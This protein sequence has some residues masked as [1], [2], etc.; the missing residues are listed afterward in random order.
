[1]QGGT[2]AIE[3]EGKI[4]EPDEVSKR[5]SDYIIQ[6]QAMTM[7]M[8]L[9]DKE[10]GWDG[11]KYVT[12]HVYAIDF[13]VGSQYI[14]EFTQ[15]NGQKAF[16]LMSLRLPKESEAES[17]DQTQARKILE[18]CL[19]KSFSFK[20]AHGIIIRVLG[21]TLGSLWRRHE[22]SDDVPGT[23]AHWLRHATTYWN[24]DDIPPPL[25]FKIME[26]LKKGP[27]LREE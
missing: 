6:G 3:E 24:Q 14:N 8:G 9:V 20:L 19:Q 17:T 10:D 4:I 11:P 22:G 7:V 1:M 25:D 15:W 26:P 16:D 5:L 12:E 13:M 2:L 18:A 27:L 23:Y 21:E